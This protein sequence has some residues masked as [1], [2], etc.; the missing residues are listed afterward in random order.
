M[1][2]FMRR[3]DRTATIFQKSEDTVKTPKLLA[4]GSL[5]GVCLTASSLAGAAPLPIYGATVDKSSMACQNWG[6]LVSCSAPFLNY[7]AGLPEQTTAT[8]GGYVLKTPQ[9]PLDSYIVVTSGGGAQGN[10]DTS[11]APAAVEDGFKSNDTGGDHF[12]ATGKANGTTVGAGNLTDPANNALTA[13]D[14]PGTWDVSA[15]WLLDALTINGVRR[16]LTMGFDFNQPQSGASMDFWGLVT[17][18]DLDGGKADINYEIQKSSVGYSLFTTGKNFA[19]MPFSTDFGTVQAATCIHSVGGVIVS[20]T[21][22]TG[23][24]C[25]AGFETKIDNAQSTA[26]TEIINFLPELNAN[27]DYLVNHDGY[28]VLSTRLLFGCFGGTDP[29]AGAGYLADAGG[30]TTN[31]ENGGFSDVFLMAG[32]PMGTVPEPGSLV[33]IGMALAALGWTAKRR[34]VG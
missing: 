18:R 3:N 11:P 34:S 24:Q 14:T 21:T 2:Y 1:A 20:V 13:G 28:D 33:L 12:L 15:K 27:L 7:L 22:I 29:K 31:C 8:N 25:P 19:S 17:L 9:G 16:E 32:A 6:D 30:S 23:A 10:S 4:L 26:N 5:L